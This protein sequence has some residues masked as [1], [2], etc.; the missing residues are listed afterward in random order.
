M[1]KGRSRELLQSIRPGMKLNKNF[2]LRIYGYELTWPGF[3][4]VALTKLQG[5]GCDKARN[6][7]TCVVAEYEYNN[8]K[9]LKNV[10]EWYIKQD[11]YG[12]KVDG[13]RKRQQSI[14]NLTRSELTE[15]CQRLL[16][17]GIITTPEQFVA[18]MGEMSSNRRNTALKW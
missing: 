11:Y 15:L 6:Y 9:V 4:E 3:A 5:A 8:E 14:Q 7:Y 13:S 1:K 18:L 12:K 2:F 16:Q 10:T 17:E